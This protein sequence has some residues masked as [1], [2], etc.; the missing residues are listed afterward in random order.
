V[1]AEVPEHV[2]QD[3]AH[4]RVVRVGDTVRRPLTPWSSSVHRLLLHLETVGYP[5]SPRFL[6]I[7]DQR[8]EVLSFIPGT[9]GADGYVEGI[10]QGGDS[11]ATVAGEGGLRRFARFLRDYHDAVASFVPH[12][13]DRWVTGPTS[14]GPA[15]TICHG[16]FG[17]WNVV[18]RGDVPVGLIDWDFAYPAPAWDDV[19]YAL[20]FV[21]PFV[22]DE[23]AVRWMRYPASPHRGR[24]IEMFLDAYGDVRERSIPDVVDDVLS[25]LGRTI[26]L[27]AQLANDGHEPQV[28]WVAK[29]Y[30]DRLSEQADWT[31]RHRGLFD[32]FGQ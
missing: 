21:A 31:D 14:D 26:A 22:D 15:G 9:S 29:G 20:R 28:T 32:P 7:D 6:G 4:R 12:R 18:W 17:P 13:D 25:R 2:L 1:P 16:D 24:R 10:E 8:R 5:Y 11:W 19:T 30:L 3:T 27:V 23:Q